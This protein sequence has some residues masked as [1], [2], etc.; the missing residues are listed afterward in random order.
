MKA[1]LDPDHPQA[2][3]ESSNSG[4]KTPSYSEV[5]QTSKSSI[6]KVQSPAKVRKTTT[7]PQIRISGIE[8]NVDAKNMSVDSDESMRSDRRCK[9]ASANTDTGVTEEG[10][11]Y[12]GQHDESDEGG[13][14]LGRVVKTHYEELKERKHMEELEDEDGVYQAQTN[15]HKRELS[16]DDWPALPTKDV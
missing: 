12:L 13:I 15:E 16:Q 11:S 1:N 6:S 9:H 5:I 2:S 3:I 8:I 10:S 4:V 7:V 14:V